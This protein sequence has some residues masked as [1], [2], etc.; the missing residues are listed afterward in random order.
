MIRTTLLAGIL[1]LGL[2]IAHALPVSADRQ[3]VALVAAYAPSQ[4]SQQREPG[5]ANLEEAIEIALERY[6]GQA[7]GADT[8]IRDGR[9][10]HE[11]RVLGED[12]SVRTVRVDPDTGEIVPQQ[13]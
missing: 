6:G 12:G 7:A 5:P 13:R 10:V 3:G 9:R 2:D 11:I 8:V 4:T 1:I